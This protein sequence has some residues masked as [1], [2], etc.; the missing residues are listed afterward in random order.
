MRI[1]AAYNRCVAWWEALPHEQRAVLLDEFTVPFCY[2][3]GKIE[4]EAITYHDTHEVFEHGRV[5]GYTGNVRTLFEIQNLQHAWNWMLGT[6]E[7]DRPYTKQSL[8]HAHDILTRGTYPE[9]LWAAG[10]RPGTYKLGDD[11]VGVDGI[12]ASAQEVPY[13]VDELLAELN[14][15][16]ASFRGGKALTIAAYAHAKL[17]GIHPFAD[18]NGRVARLLMNRELLRRKHPPV[19]IRKEQRLA[20]YGALDAFHREGDLDALEAFLKIACISDWGG[21]S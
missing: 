7:I 18:G 6:L 17:V 21:R 12:G 20:Y 2:N 9:K 10:E 8:L 1:E 16:P 5:I 19:A 15:A 3:S 14:G 11:I 13:L 4:N